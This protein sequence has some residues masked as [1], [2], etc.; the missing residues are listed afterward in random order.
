MKKSQ[1][2]FTLDDRIEI[3]KGLD[4]GL[5][6]KAIAK[7]L[8]KHQTSVS[9]EVV[10]HIQL[11]KTA[12]IRK[13][14]QGNLVDRPCKLILKA[15]YVCNP[16]KKK[17]SACS[18]DKHIYC[19]KSAHNTYSKT[20]VDCRSGIALNKEQFYQNDKLI[21]DAINNGMH[22]YQ[23][24]QSYDLGVCEST[25]YNH[26]NKGY[27]SFCSL[28]LPRKVKFKPRKPK[29]KDYISQ[30]LKANRSYNDFLDY[31]AQNN[32]SHWVE[33]DTVIGSVGG[34]AILTL[35]FTFCNLM[36]AFLLDDLNSATVSNKIK[37]I[38]L[39]MLNNGLVFGHY[40]PVILTDNG[41]EF[42]DIFAI[43][44]DLNGNQETKLFFCQPYSSYQKPHVEKNHTLFRDI[45]PK[46]TCFNNLTQSNLNTIFSHVNSTARRN[47][48]GKSP[49][50][51]FS[52]TFSKALPCI[53]DIS[54]IPPQYVIQS[55][56]LLK[57][58]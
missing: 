21:T 22:I 29:P 17:R 38:K 2:H 27:Y 40:L 35:D 11:E 7:K 28:D 1:N 19:A 14:E 44:N 10:R 48:N 50:D 18:F 12:V 4:Y 41:G 49:L 16:C 24:T 57:N 42:A 6:F 53:F 23:I 34:K 3:Q 47:L 30:G 39:T 5:S 31:I 52:F 45:C 43:E 37:D 9:R 20:L 46:G 56:V 58:L 54:H 36:L 32:I 8:G 13:D 15:P 51:V 55:P 33:M 26:V 25:I